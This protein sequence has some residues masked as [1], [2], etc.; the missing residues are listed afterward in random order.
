MNVGITSEKDFTSERDT[1]ETKF[2]SL[3]KKIWIK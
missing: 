1:S 2:F 3:V